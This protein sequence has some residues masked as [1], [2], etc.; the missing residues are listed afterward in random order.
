MRRPRPMEK[1]SKRTTRTDLGPLSAFQE[2]SMAKRSRQTSER[3][4]RN[5][6]QTLIEL[7]GRLENRPSQFR[8][9][10]T[11]KKAQKVVD[12][13]LKLGLPGM[14]RLEGILFV[15]TIRELWSLVELSLRRGY[16]AI[17]RAEGAAARRV[18]LLRRI[19]ETG[20]NKNVRL[21][22]LRAMG[23]ALADSRHLWETALPVLA[24]CRKDADKEIAE[25]AANTLT[26]VTAAKA[27][28][29]RELLVTRIDFSA[30]REVLLLAI[31]LTQRFVGSTD[32]SL[33][34]NALF[35][36]YGNVLDREVRAAIEDALRAHRRNHPKEYRDAEAEYARRTQS[37][38]DRLIV[39]R[40]GE[41]V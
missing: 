30:D 27:P 34:I 9:R 37:W 2:R 18:S 36:C 20:E 24:S 23:A 19:C 17:C 15:I 4:S 33:A 22:A 1:R 13:L 26:P 35:H 7:A 11:L 16:N 39:R 25:T 12:E 14:G 32:V 29:V 8:L 6:C 31:P 3:R 10:S 38:V 28:W 40:I 21:W 41:G 5:L